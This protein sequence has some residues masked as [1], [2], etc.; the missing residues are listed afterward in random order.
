MRYVK[1]LLRVLLALI[2][3][4]GGYAVYQMYRQSPDLVNEAVARVGLA[5][6]APAP[7][8]VQASGTL[9]APRVQVMSLVPARVITVTVK[10]GDTVAAGEVLIRL[11]D[12]LLQKQLAAAAADIDVARA[13]LALLEAGPRREEIAK[14]RAQ[15]TAARV[16][17]DVAAQGVEDAR[18][19][20]DAAQDV[21]PE[22]IRAEMEVTK[23]L[24]LRD[25]ALARAQAADITVDLW[26]R[27][28]DQVKAGKTVTLPTGEVKHI[29]PPPEKVNEVSFQWN[30]ASQ[31]AWQA[32]AQYE[33]AK[34]AVAAARAKLEAARARLD[35]PSRNIPVA[36]AVA[37]YEKA[38]AAVPV[39]QAGLDA[40]KQGVNE[41]KIEAARANLRRAQAAYDRMAANRRYYTI[42]A[43]I[44][45]RVLSL[46][47]HPG[48][49]ALPGVSL[50][51]LADTSVLRLTIYV[52]EEDLGRV[53]LGQDVAVTVDAFP[54]RVFHGTVVHIA[55]E[56]EFTPKNVQTRE[57]RTTLVYAVEVKVPND[58]GLLKPGM[59]ADATLNGR[60][61]ESP[62]PSTLTGIRLPVTGPKS[63]PSPQRATSFTVSGTFEATEV[64]VV[65][66]VSARVLDVLVD[67]GDVVEQ[68]DVVAHLDPG[69]LPQRLEEAQAALAA[70]E[71]QLADLKA[72]PL[73]AQV[74]VARAQVSQAQ[75]EVRAAQ[76]ALSAAQAALEQPTELENQIAL[77]KAQLG[78]LEQRLDGARAQ[79]KLAVV[80]RDYYAAQIT[81]EARIRRD[82]AEKMVAA[83]EAN[84]KAVQA[85]IAGTKRLIAYLQQVREHPLV[86]EAQVHQ[87]EGQVRLAQARLEVARKALALAQAPA[88]GEEIAAAEARVAQARATIALLR[89]QLQ[90][91]SLTAPISGRVLNRLVEPGE[92]AQAGKVVMHIGDLSALELTVFVPEPDLGY[93]QLGQEVDVRVDTYPDRTFK[94]TVVW[95][96]DE[97]EFTPKNVQ[98]REDR[99]ETVYRV[100][101][102]VP[103]PEGILKPGMPADATFH[104]P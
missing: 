80:E 46:A 35:D 31:E 20:R 90:R 74:K 39:A 43:P 41:E 81:D 24:Y 66:E 82:I 55:E 93:V 83:A 27:I 76:V 86:L 77:L 45:G 42:T 59:P 17:V 89:A 30:K 13:Q 26:R 6:T 50:V 16:A 5:T 69:D 88:R 47:I 98:T 99:M 21:W 92:V 9:E 36:Q 10:E 71:A 1:T 72:Q 51:E 18:A 64:R 94:G 78:V 84:L 91:Y 61:E 8:I 87:A 75:A 102:R 12:T 7:G 104:G 2:L 68:G 65:P 23:T 70:A 53:R 4:G 103:N 11:D 19:I 32:W 73:P 58:E 100:K 85:E 28:N 22:I 44:S 57:E 34:A 49:V 97:A 56:A 40:L 63:S 29:A 48:E 52:A 62:Q 37:A 96:A 54:N 38:L 3:I 33:E 25:A 101:V 60:G 79:R 15:L 95:I 14:A 67:K